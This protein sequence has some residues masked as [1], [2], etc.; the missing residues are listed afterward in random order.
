MSIIEENHIENNIVQE[1]TIINSIV[2][3][4]NLEDEKIKKSTY[5]ES[6]KKATK[7]WQ[8]KNAKEL[9]QKNK[10]RLENWL[11]NT[12]VSKKE[13]MQKHYED[14]KEKYKIR[15]R[16]AYLRKKEKLKSESNIIL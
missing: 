6:Q 8:Q 7:K 14:N 5:T 13:Y 1:N 15:N 16:E 3:V 11:E 10:G 4:D 12:G 9:Y 2:V